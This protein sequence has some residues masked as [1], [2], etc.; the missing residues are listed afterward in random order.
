MTAEPVQS[1]HTR[2][3]RSHHG[4]NNSDLSLFSAFNKNRRHQG[5]SEIREV[6][7]AVTAT[8]LGIDPLKP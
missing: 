5:T 7:K 4:I 6:S 1:P 8:M 2:S 3:H